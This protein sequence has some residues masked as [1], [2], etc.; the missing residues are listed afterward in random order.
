MAAA[1]FA[2]CKGGAMHVEVRQRSATQRS[3]E[4][5]AAYGSGVST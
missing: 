4:P 3:S 1:R 5:R 2:R